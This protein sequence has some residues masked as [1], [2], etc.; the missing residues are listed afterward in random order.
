LTN[1]EIGASQTET[2][3][4]NL[5]PESEPDRSQ[6]TNLELEPTQ[7]KTDERIASFSQARSEAYETSL[8][9]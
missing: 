8:N 2:R 7:I 3:E 5:K 4:T 6:L 1:I 9:A